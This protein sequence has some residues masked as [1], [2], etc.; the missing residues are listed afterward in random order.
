MANDFIRKVL[1]LFSEMR[2]RERRKDLSRVQLEGRIK[3][4]KRF[5][6]IKWKPKGLKD[7]ERAHWWQKYA[8]MMNG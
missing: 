6:K 7:S 8:N 1:K 3:L 2:E 4:E 5:T